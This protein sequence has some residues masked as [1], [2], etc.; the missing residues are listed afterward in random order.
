MSTVTKRVREHKHCLRCPYCGRFIEHD[1]DEFY[2][3]YNREDESS[4]VACFCSEDHADEY[5]ARNKALRHLRSDLATNGKGGG[6]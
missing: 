4:Y 3:R 1:A 6:A 5:H 2:D